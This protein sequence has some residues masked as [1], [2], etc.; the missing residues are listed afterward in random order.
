MMLNEWDAISVVHW[1]KVQILLSIF[2]V[3]FK[4]IEVYVYKVQTVIVWFFKLSKL[5]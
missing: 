4:Y 5:C 3:F 2:Q 1:T